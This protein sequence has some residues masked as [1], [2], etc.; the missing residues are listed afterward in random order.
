L[1]AALLLPQISIN[2]DAANLLIHNNSESILEICQENE[3]AGYL[4]L[5][6]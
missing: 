4:S 3:E 2:M 6:I 5:S 1:G